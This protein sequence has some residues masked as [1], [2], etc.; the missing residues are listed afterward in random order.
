MG[1]NFGNAIS[2]AGTGA[3]FGSAAG[4][5]GAVI[6]GVAGGVAGGFT[7]TPDPNT[8][9]NEQAAAQK[10]FQERM[11]NTAHQREVADLKAA[12]LNPI[13]SANSAGA[14]TPVGSMAQTFDKGTIDIQRRMLAAQT[15][16]LIANSAKTIAD[17]KKTD[18]ESKIAQEQAK[19]APEMAQAN[20]LSATANSATSVNQAN[21][22]GVQ[23]KFWTSPGG[24]AAYAARQYGDAIGSW[25]APITGAYR[26]FKGSSARG[27]ADEGYSEYVRERPRVKTE[28]VKSR[29]GDFE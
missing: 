5:W 12:G 14:S 27:L 1:F 20:L 8:N 25:I 18:A 9:A 28:R 16:N 17:A 13:L 7:N 2:G 4:P 21:I 24:N 19:V 26:T 23:S 3:S 29:G 6:G 22:S 10:E 11:S 15:A